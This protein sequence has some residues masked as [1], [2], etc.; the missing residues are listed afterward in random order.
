M[1][2]FLV[3]DDGTHNNFLICLLNSVK[4][5]GSQF[6]IIIFNK[7]Q[8]DNDFMIKNK[9]ILSL[10]RGG[11]YWLW[12]PYIIN[13]VLNKI[14]DD[15]VIFY[16]DSKYYFIEDF[17]NLYLEYLTTNDLLVWN[18]KP[19]EHTWD[20]KNWCKMDVILKYNMYDKIF[21]ENIKDCWAGAIVVKKT[22]NTIKYMQEWLDMCCIHEDITDSPSIAENSE[23]YR[24]HRHDQSLLNIVLQKYNI[25]TPIFENRYLQNMRKRF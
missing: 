19:N 14:N 7:N 3:Y 16:L 2:Y 12:K 25:K 17:A 10:N 20:M 13:N 9:A 18:N 11:G 5:Y 6:E 24:E 4:K 8:I 15:D 23:L 22:K 1:Y 21:I